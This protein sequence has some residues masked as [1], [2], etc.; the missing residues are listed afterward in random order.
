MLSIFL[1]SLICTTFAACKPEIT[2]WKLLLVALLP[3]SQESP[4]R[5]SYH[6][7]LIIK[8][9]KTDTDYPFSVQRKGINTLKMIKIN[10]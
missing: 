10:K 3:Y 2:T 5:V 4:Q 6:T 1:D 7:T 8:H 9:F